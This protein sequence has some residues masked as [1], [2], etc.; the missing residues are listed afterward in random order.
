MLNINITL[1]WGLIKFF[2]SREIQE[3]AEATGFK[4]RESKLQP[5]TFFKAFTVGL[6]SL[7]IVTLTTL[8]SKCEDLQEQLKLTRQ[9]LFGRMG[10]GA[11][12]LKELLNQ[13]MDHAA[14][15]ILSTE[16]VE[17]LKQFQ[18]VYVCDSSIISLPDKLEEQHKGLGGTN[19]KA[20]VKI[21]TVFSIASRTFKIIEV[22]ETTGNDSSK[23]TDLV[24]KLLMM[25]L[26]IFDLGYYNANE[27]LV[28][29]IAGKPHSKSPMH[30]G[31][32]M[33]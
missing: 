1:I 13:A 12:F 25:E 11:A 27:S 6:W 20:A 14:K 8:A 29:V 21:Q 15:K 19:A 9:G 22:F 16:T 17:V 28:E 30:K 26:I 2:T 18:D 7:H 32:L 5:D 4:R 24:A 10:T 33:C 23:T 31:D 3:A